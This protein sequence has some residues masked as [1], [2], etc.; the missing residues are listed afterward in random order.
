VKIQI[1]GKPEFEISLT[2]EHVLLLMK[3]SSCH[4]DS[5]CKNASQPR[6]FL[7]GWNNILGLTPDGETLPIRATWHEL[8]T[9][10]KII[11]MPPPLTADEIH[12]RAE[13]Q[14]CFFAAFRL[15]NEV[16]SAWTVTLEDPA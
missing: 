6:G 8:D 15:A 9:V 10:L 1:Q 2:K 4:Y 7:F 11:E 13:M 3:L 14:R 12:L 16:Y 5:R